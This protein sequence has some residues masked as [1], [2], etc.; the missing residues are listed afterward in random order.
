MQKDLRDV[1][2]IFMDGGKLPEL[3]KNAGF[4]DVQRR[5][6]RIEIGAWGPGST[7]ATS[8]ISVIF[9]D[10][11]KHEFATRCVN[12]W[13][14]GMQAFAVQFI[15]QHGLHETEASEFNEDIAQEFRN[16]DNQF[17]SDGFGPHKS[18]TYY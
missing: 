10:P 7:P 6:I 5:K 2:G 9:V 8:F 18:W 17:Y 4:V 1:K 11:W 13:T 12:I 16:L 14:A 15:E 3:V